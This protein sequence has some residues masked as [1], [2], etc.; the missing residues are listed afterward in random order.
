[1]RHTFNPA[2]YVPQRRLLAQ[3][4]AA[5]EKYLL[6]ISFGRQPDTPDMYR[7]DQ[8]ETISRQESYSSMRSRCRAGIFLPRRNRG[9]LCMSDM[10]VY[11]QSFTTLLE[12]I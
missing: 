7:L 2:E 12:H 8:A 3:T 11:R 6:S 4:L 9:P 1:M 5:A 10:N